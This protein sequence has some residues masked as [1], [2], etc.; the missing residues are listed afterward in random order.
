MG[1]TFVVDRCDT[2]TLSL[3]N[4]QIVGCDVVHDADKTIAAV[5]WKSLVFPR[6]D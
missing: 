2:V 5:P 3:L 4:R 1:L 6:F